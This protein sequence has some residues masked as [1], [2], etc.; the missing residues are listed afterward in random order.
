MD[1]NRGWCTRCSFGEGLRLAPYR[2][3]GKLRGSLRAL[4]T[5]QN[6]LAHSSLFYFR[7]AKN[8][9]SYKCGYPVLCQSEYPESVCFVLF[10]QWIK[11]AGPH[12]GKG[13]YWCCPQAQTRAFPPK[14][15]PVISPA[16]S[17]QGHIW[18]QWNAEG[19]STLWLSRISPQEACWLFKNIHPI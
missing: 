4:V 13:G 1:Q 2:G 9:A 3:P 17:V 15:H 5:H 8:N 12:L 16:L 18:P 19:S 11:W 10:S 7:L 6:D 14:R